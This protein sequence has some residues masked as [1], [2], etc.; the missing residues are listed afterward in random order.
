[1]KDKNG[2][3]AHSLSVL[4]RWTLAHFCQ[5]LNAH[6]VNDVRMNLLFEDDVAIGKLNG[7]CN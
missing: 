4:N 6:G 5:L 1:M 2:E 7:F 3:L